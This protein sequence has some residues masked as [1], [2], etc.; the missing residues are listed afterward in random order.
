M[1]FG[2][3]AETAP[4]PT[5]LYLFFTNPLLKFEIM[6]KGSVFIGTSGWSYKHWKG[7]FYPEKLRN[8]EYLE[9]YSK[10][11]N[12]VELNSTF[13][14]LPIKNVFKNWHEKTPKSFHFSAKLSR[15]I[16]RN[17]RLKDAKEP[18]ANFMDN[19]LTLG[20]KLSVVFAQLPG[21]F[22]KDKKRLGDFLKL[23]KRKGRFAFEFRHISWFDE[24]IYETLRGQNLGIVIAD[25]DRWPSKEVITS[26]FIYLRFHGRN[27][28]YSGNYSDS[29]LSIWAKK[30]KDWKNSGY[31]IYAYFNNDFNAYAVKNALKL[32]VLLEKDI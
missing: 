7:I 13:Y 25:S 17:L 18:L 8:N 5:L 21:N 9:Y 28:L 3:S 32:K 14:R 29:T 15:Y 31:D 26:N 11:F 23:L 6:Q 10:S 2:I 16:T 20:E 24:E 27:G 19:S 12:T 22:K 1:S 30:I 4:P